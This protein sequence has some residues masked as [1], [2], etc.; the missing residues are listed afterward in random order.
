[1]VK[2]GVGYWF[3][4]QADLYC[5]KMRNYKWFS[6]KLSYLL[7]KVLCPSLRVLFRAGAGLLFN[8]VKPSTHWAKPLSQI[9]QTA[10][11]CRGPAA[12]PSGGRHRSPGIPVLWFRHRGCRAKPVGLDVASSLVQSH[13]QWQRSGITHAPYLTLGQERSQLNPRD[14]NVSGF[15]TH[16]PYTLSSHCPL[17]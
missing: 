1:M 5:K 17:Y 10:W 13:L 14:L 16:L 6:L 3:S 8:L 15:W 2:H 11:R 9:L 4:E 7:S 12:L